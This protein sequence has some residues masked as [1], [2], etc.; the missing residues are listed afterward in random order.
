M[1][2]VL[3]NESVSIELQPG[4]HNYTVSKPGFSDINGTIY[5]EAGQM[6]SYPI[7]CT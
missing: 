2:E 4:E 3:G 6:Y 1:H 5:L 7:T